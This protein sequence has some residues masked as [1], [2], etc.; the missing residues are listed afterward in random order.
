MR[1]TLTLVLVAPLLTILLALSTGCQSLGK[2]S[3][4]P[5]PTTQYQASLYTP[6]Q[7]DA[8][9]R[10]I[11]INLIYG[12]ISVESN[13]AVTVQL[14]SANA[15]TTFAVQFCPAP[16]QNYNCFYVGSVS[17]DANGNAN[18][19]VTFPKSGSWAGDFELVSG[20][21]TA[22]ETDIQS[23]NGSPVYM[24]TLQP[25][26]TVNGH[27]L[28]VG[29]PPQDPLS[30]GSVTFS[31]GSLQF[32]MTGASANTSYS[33][34]ECAL[35]LESSCSELYDSHGTGGFTTNGSG[36]VTFSALQDGSGGDIFE[37]TPSTGSGFVGGF[38]VRSGD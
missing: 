31:N 32:Q 23:G 36:S 30:S 34:A 15:S 1:R 10:Q 7:G 28:G 22:Y 13:G 5:A 20:G 19:T 35:N 37:V 17:S 24:S 38:A 21:I 9:G 4:S 2:G 29:Q 14:A 8:M 12:Q 11:V 18:T 27:G 33:S 6:V 25:V 3:S 16:S 26:S